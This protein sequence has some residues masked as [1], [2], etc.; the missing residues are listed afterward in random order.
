[1]TEIFFALTIIYAGYV[2]FVAV[3]D[4]KEP[5]VHS[6]D[7]SAEALFSVPHHTLSEPEKLDVPKE[8]IV[9]D[10]KLATTKK[11]LKN[12]ET[13][14]IATS[15]ANYRFTKRWIKD[16]LVK[17]SLLDK[18]YKNNELNADVEAKIKKAIEQLENIERY[19]A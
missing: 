10:V 17:E 11:G 15:Y 5:P 2:I 18:I 19:Q 8:I 16:A 14:E 1:M 6:I 7:D 13:G 3:T 12:P 9:K 4:K